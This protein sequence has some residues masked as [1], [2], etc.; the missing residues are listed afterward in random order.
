M[1][2]HRYQFLHESHIAQR[3]AHL[4]FVDDLLQ[5]AGAQQ[6]HG[7][8]HN[9]SGFN[10][11]EP[12]RHH[13]RVVGRTQQHARSRNQLQ[14][15]L[16][17]MCDLVRAREQLPVGAGETLA[18]DF[19]VQRDA[20]AAAFGNVAVEQ[21]G[22]AVQTFGKL[23]FGKFEY[24]FGPLIFR[25]Q[26]IQ[27]E[28]V[29]VSGVSQDDFL[30]AVVASDAEFPPDSALTVVEV[31]ERAI[32]RSRLLE[33]RQM[34]GGWNDDEFRRRESRPGCR[35]PSRPACPRPARRRSPASGR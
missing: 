16:Q 18:V 34:R 2:L 19:G 26:I 24:A 3:R 30:G 5:F 29:D 10:H 9:A 1:H 13:H 31:G 33:V 7:R 11:R 8:H 35:A 27:N 12:A 25:R 17:Y 22:G 6:R 14:V 23:Q 4:R 32:E 21:F 20:L 28:S 15:A